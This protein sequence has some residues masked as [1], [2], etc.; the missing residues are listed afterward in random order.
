L[1]DEPTGNLDEANSERVFELL[2]EQTRN[3][4]AA[5]ILVTHDQALAARC[6]RVMT[7]HLGELVPYAPPKIA[8]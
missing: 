4:G 8:A 6:D 3:R 7:L 2:L 1:A 5:L